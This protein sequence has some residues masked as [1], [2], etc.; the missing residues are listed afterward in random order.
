MVPTVAEMSPVRNLIV[1]YAT[2]HNEPGYA[3]RTPDR[4]VL[5][6]DHSAHSCALANSDIPFLIHLGDVNT[7]EA[8]ALV[9]F[10]AGGVAAISVSRK[11]EVA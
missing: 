1:R 7:A 5:F 6:V 10:L 3:I 4:R 9:D 8:Q 11:Q 2:F